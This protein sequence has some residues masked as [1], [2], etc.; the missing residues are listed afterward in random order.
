MIRFTAL[1]LTFT[2]PQ[3][4]SAQ[5][6]SPQVPPVETHSTSPDITGTIK[7]VTLYQGTAIVTRRVELPAAKTGTFELVVT[8]LPT[9]TDPTS[10]HA[11]RVE[12]AMVR[13]VSCRSRPPEEASKLA[14]QVTELDDAIRTLSRKIATSKNEI[15]LRRIRQEYLRGL[16]N[17][18]APAATQEMTHGVIQAD[19]L[20]AVTQMHFREYERASQEIMTMSSSIEDDTLEL[21]ELRKQRE[22]LAAGPPATFDAI[23]FIEKKEAGPASLHLNYLVKDCGWSPLYNVRANTADNALEI[24]F[25]AIIHQ[26]SGEDWK[27]AS[28]ALSTASPKTS[29]YNPR[30]TPLY[31]GVSEDDSTINN[32]NRV[33]TY[34]RAQEDKKAAM[35]SQFRGKS[36]DENSADNFKANES[37]ASVQLIE[38][39]ERLS[40]LRLMRDNGTE[41]DLSIRYALESP[42]T[43]VSRR[44][45][46][47]VPVL[48]HNSSAAFYHVASPILTSAVFREAELTNES[49]H[50]LLGGQVNVFLDGEFTGRTEI[51]TIARGRNFT[52]G[53]GVDGQL[54]AR[55]SL[56]DRTETVQG[57]NRQVTISSDVV[58]DNFKTTPVNL[59]LRE[60]TPFMEDTASLRVALG[61][62]SHPISSDSD[63]KRFERPKG[64]L[65]WDLEVPPG[66]NDNAFSLSYTYTLEFDKNVA[67]RDISNE[68][69]SRLRS[70]FIQENRRANKK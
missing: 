54:R 63:Y 2:L 24:E 19:Q 20:E 40:E 41:E 11:D 12:G 70:E 44:D 37:A 33:A 14:S 1:I 39:S 64:V 10:V 56:I 23:V 66:A 68:Q 16:E 55:R 31:V 15:A 13:S 3:L 9:A 7:E 47:M 28:L 27:E 58:I 53:F 25:N 26:V 5:E 59:R 8:S 43:L 46:Q 35:L 4:A 34:N 48:R 21:G 32:P 60:R 52:L 29:A 17:F 30:L 67:L 65:R 69:K 42:V 51:P 61:E 6:E 22:K 50:D 62:M 18:V 49:N 45:Q 36:I 38:L 57:G